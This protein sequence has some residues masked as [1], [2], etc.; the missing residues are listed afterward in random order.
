[1]PCTRFATST[2]AVAASATSVANSAA[3]PPFS[4]ISCLPRCSGFSALTLA[5]GVLEAGFDLPEEEWKE[6]L[7][8][9]G[10]QSAATFDQFVDVVA[11]LERVGSNGGK[12][13]SISH[14]S[15][16]LT[17]Q[18]VAVETISEQDVG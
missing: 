9:V 11:R 6:L 12:R 1:M 5:G 4:C 18:E 3:I 8:T 14:V 15:Q 10:A 13:F 16:A 17:R 2:S 7:L